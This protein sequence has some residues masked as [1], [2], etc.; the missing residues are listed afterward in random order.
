[1]TTVI[2]NSDA[3]ISGATGHSKGF[4][5]PLKFDLDRS[6]G[7]LFIPVFVNIA[8]DFIQDGCRRTSISGFRFGFGVEL[9]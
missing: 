9:T 2:L 6:F 5:V 4:P 8:R 1:M 7:M 3:L